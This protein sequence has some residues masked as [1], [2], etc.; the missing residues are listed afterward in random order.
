MK[1]LILFYLI[2]SADKTPEK[3]RLLILQWKFDLRARDRLCTTAPSPPLP[4]KISGRDSLLDCFEGGTGPEHERPWGRGCQM[5][6]RGLVPAA[7]A[8]GT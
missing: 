4:S 2:E 7:V 8:A 3:N 6:S 1:V 5:L